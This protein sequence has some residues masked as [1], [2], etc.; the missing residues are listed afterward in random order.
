MDMAVAQKLTPV[1]THS[2]KFIF[3]NGPFSLYIRYGYGKPK[4]QFYDAPGGFNLGSHNWLKDRDLIERLGKDDLKE[5]WGISKAGIIALKNND[6]ETALI[7]PRITQRHIHSMQD[8]HVLDDI[9]LIMHSP[10][11]TKKTNKVLAFKK[12]KAEVVVAKKEY[13]PLDSAKSKLKLL[14]MNGLDNNFSKTINAAVQIIGAYFKQTTGSLVA[15]VRF[16][17]TDRVITE[18]TLN[19]TARTYDTSTDDE[20]ALNTF[21]NCLT[22]PHGDNPILVRGRLEIKLSRTKPGKIWT[23]LFSD[24]FNPVEIYQEVLDEV[25]KYQ[26][27]YLSEPREIDIIYSSVGLKR[28]GFSIPNGRN[29]NFQGWGYGWLD[30]ARGHKFTYAVK[31]VGWFNTPSTKDFNIVKGMHVNFVVQNLEAKHD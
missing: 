4:C 19:L 13:N 14:T 17:F 25:E 24:N 18:I 10:P 8:N 16:D 9:G 21:L 23:T 20:G 5:V 11:H 6:E 12:S 7:D 22:T 28:V 27:E 31:D 29:H 30:G 26:P 1:K 2:L 3:N 15:V